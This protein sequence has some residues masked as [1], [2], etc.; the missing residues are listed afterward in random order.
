MR[1]LLQWVGVQWFSCMGDLVKGISVDQSRGC[2]GFVL[3]EVGDI[4]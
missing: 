3:S 4:V 2:E 1:G